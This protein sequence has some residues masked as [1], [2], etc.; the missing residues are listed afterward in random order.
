[1]S[2]KARMM[3]VKTM[4][5]F[6]QREQIILRIVETAKPNKQGVFVIQLTGEELNFLRQEVS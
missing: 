2:K 6:Y 3:L 1:M 4:H 5:R